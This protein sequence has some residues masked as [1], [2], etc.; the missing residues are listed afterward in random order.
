[1]QK[2][3]VITSDIL[4]RDEEIGRT[5]IRLFLNNLAL[6]TAVPAQIILVNAGVK[7]AC[8]GSDVLDSL[9]RLAER[10]VAIHACGTCLDY[11]DLRAQLRVGDG[12]TMAD[13]VVSLMSADDALFVS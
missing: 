3:M 4:G 1:M 5:L 6:S 11:Y 2:T 13:T 12:G 7:L 10:E 8:E 9:E